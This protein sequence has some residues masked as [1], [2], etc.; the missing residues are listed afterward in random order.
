MR[1]REIQNIPKICTTDI[2]CNK[3]GKSLRISDLPGDVV[4][5]GGLIGA[6]VEGS[7]YS[8]FGD[9]IS[10]EF[11]LCEECIL[12]MF[13]TFKIPPEEHIVDVLY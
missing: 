5:Y 12:E 9:C 8:K 1:E 11:D 6:L 2:K 10:Y 3:C 4:C 7:C 13:D